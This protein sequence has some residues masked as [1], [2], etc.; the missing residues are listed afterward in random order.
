MTS[1]RSTSLAPAASPGEVA[2]GLSTTVAGLLVALLGTTPE[3][4]GALLV[5]LGWVPYGVKLLVRAGGL[6]GVWRQL[7]GE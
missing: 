2:G 6:R 4:A 1:K 3:V 7:V 5:V